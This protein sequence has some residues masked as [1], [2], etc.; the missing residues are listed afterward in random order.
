MATVSKKR[1]WHSWYWQRNR[2]FKPRDPCRLSA[3]P[4]YPVYSTNAGLM[5]AIVAEA[6]PPL[7]QHRLNISCLLPV[8]VGGGGGGRGGGG[9]TWANSAHI[10]LEN[11]RPQVGLM[12]G[13]RRRRWTST[14]PTL[15]QCLVFAVWSVPPPPPR[16]AWAVKFDPSRTC[17]CHT[18]GWSRSH[19][20]LPSKH[21][22]NVDWMLCQ[23]LR[24]WASIISTLAQRLVFRGM[25]LMDIKDVVLL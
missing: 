17:A 12:L 1:V 19:N 11:T 20:I 7:T 23:H 2:F 16:R 24:R 10:C 18:S 13:Q 4:E 8:C 9:G 22:I 25:Y 15:G 21:W 14:K 5:L 6:G 3:S